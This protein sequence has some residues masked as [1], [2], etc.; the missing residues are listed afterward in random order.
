MFESKLWY[1]KTET[2]NAKVSKWWNLSKHDQCPR[3]FNFGHF[4]SSMVLL[5]SAEE[6]YIFKKYFSGEMN[7]FLLPGVVMIK[8]WHR[9][10][11]GGMSKS[12]QIQ[13]FDYKRARTVIDSMFVYNFVDLELRVETFFKKEGAVKNGGIDFEIGEIGTS[14]HLY[15]R[16]KKVS[17]RAWGFFIIFL[18]TK[19]SF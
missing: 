9:G 8:T 4:F 5:L 12:E 10:L 11:L 18:V 7:N 3:K 13:Y 19:N 14:A 1:C 16:L 17:W 15:W 2:K 6:K